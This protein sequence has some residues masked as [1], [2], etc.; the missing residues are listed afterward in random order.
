MILRS[1]PETYLGLESVTLRVR[2]SEGAYTDYSLEKVKVFPA[3]DVFTIDMN[4]ERSR[5]IDLVIW[6]VSLTKVGVTSL[7]PGDRIVRNSGMEYVIE[8]LDERD[9]L[10]NYFVTA[11][12]VVSGD[13]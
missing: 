12:E 9:E 7:R 1:Y 5:T 11:R 4:L 3:N 6:Q 8:E 10:Q 2:Q 13:R